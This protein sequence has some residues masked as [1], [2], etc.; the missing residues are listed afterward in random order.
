MRLLVTFA[1]GR[2]HL[3]PLLPIALAARSFGHEVAIAGAAGF[4]PSI[5]RRGYRFFPIGEA[6]S[7]GPPLRIPLARLDLDKEDRDLRDGFARRLGRRHA[8][9]LVAIADQWRPDVLLRDEADFGAAVAGERLG[10]PV[11]T[12]LVMAS[13]AFVRPW[14]VAEPL[15]ELR[16]EH[17]LP[18]DPDLAMLHRD[19]VL[20]PF[21]PSLRD[22]E[23]ALP[24]TAR[25]FRGVDVVHRV[26][27]AGRPS[28][29]FTL[30]TVFSLE[31]GDL[32]ERVL[33]GLADLDVD[34]VATVG[35]DID[36][37]EF[38][39]Q[40]EGIRVER[41]VLQATLLAMV[42]VMI[43]HG[44]S[45]GMLG[46]LAHG[47][48]QVLIPLGADQ[49]HNSARAAALG[50]ARVLDA[51]D[52]TPADVADAVRDV[53]LDPSYRHRAEQMRDELAAQPSPTDAIPWI[54][55][56]TS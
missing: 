16:A 26:V 46:A 34:V 49:P 24:S 56:L 13:G 9:A 29:Y 37:A 48:P 40:R 54:T 7:P 45:G 28:V 52:T 47:L 32:F 6:P 33:A 50:L 10:L 2:G 22:P 44:G 20:C 31:C 36:P 38:G 35:N 25:S 5:E 51:Y 30:G 1:G 11:V 43:S 8:T 4:A 12:V 23:F 39:R 27:H 55:A 53:L 41:F 3:E 19:L 21:P 15:H 14:V 42:D 18:S 17:G